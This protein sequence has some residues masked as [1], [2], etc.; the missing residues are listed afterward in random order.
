MIV[1]YL[2]LIIFCGKFFYPLFVK[3]SESDF[4]LFPIY[5]VLGFGVHFFTW[6]LLNV[7]FNSH[8]PIFSIIVISVFGVVGL[9]FTLKNNNFRKFDIKNLQQYAA[10]LISFLL[11]SAQYLVDCFQTIKAAITK[12]GIIY[13]DIPYHAGI[14]NSI[15]EFGF[16]VKDIFYEGLVIKYHIFSHFIASQFSYITN[17]DMVVVYVTLF[18]IITLLFFSFLTYHLIYLLTNKK[19]NIFQMIII[20]LI[21]SNLFF[22]PGKR[23]WGLNIPRYFSYSYMWQAICFLTIVIL[24]EKFYRKYNSLFLLNMKEYTILVFLVGLAIVSKGSSLPIL[25]F[26]FAMLFLIELIKTRKLHPKYAFFLILLVTS[27]VLIFYVFFKTP[28]LNS[29]LNLTKINFVILKNFIP[30]KIDRLILTGCVKTKMSY[31]KLIPFI[32][33]IFS[34]FGTLNF[35]LFFLR[36]IFKI[37][38]VG[39][40]IVSFTV[41]AFYFFMV[42]TSNPW[43]F[44]Y[45]T[46]FL[47]GI[48]AITIL[49]NT[50]KENSLIVKILAPILIVMTLY[51][52]STFGKTNKTYLEKYKSSYFPMT[53][54]K[55][56][57]YENLKINT[58]KSDV[59]FTPSLYASPDSMADNYYPQAYTGRRFLLTGYRCGYGKYHEDFSNRKFLCDN[60]N[61]ISDFTNTELKRY[62]INYILIEKDIYDH[63]AF[64]KKKSKVKN[65]PN[66]NIIYE[67]NAGLLLKANFPP[68]KPSNPDN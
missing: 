18:E 5:G 56:S 8:S 36:K 30:D 37:S 38:H 16:P 64:S 9:Y 62:N 40:L 3:E 55:F 4:Y 34:I 67:N 2:V 47:T 45:V 12:E 53:K 51:P 21:V 65:N 49:I 43:Y 6:F 63:A 57:L 33:I 60:L 50:W 39:V 35:R 17:Y 59:I 25:I 48:Y 29:N 44:Y 46:M 11:L 19:L 26:G 31:F 52:I 61:F 58:N 28:Y 41:C 23:Y 32:T 24:L 20:V 14:S 27:S 15:I 66:F 54:D 10:P 22:F 7:I 13:Q 1:V 42:S 68:S